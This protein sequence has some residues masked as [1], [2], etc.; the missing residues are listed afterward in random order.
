MKTLFVVEGTWSAKPYGL[1]Y[2]VVR[3]LH[4]DWNVIPVDYPQSF[5]DPLSFIRSVATGERNLRR[6]IKKAEGQYAI[7]GYSQGALV[8]GNVAA[9]LKDPRFINVYLIADPARS[10][11]DTLIGPPVLG[12]GIFGQRVVGPKAY[13]FAAAGDW[14]ADNCNPALS[15]MASYAWHM[16]WSDPHGWIKSWRITAR[17]RQHGGS[18]TRALLTVLKSLRNGVHIRYD[19]HVVAGT[20]TVTQ[21]IAHDLNAKITTV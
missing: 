9:T 4:S 12:E 13:Q 10:K 21:W 5:G 8:A 20:M 1:S 15:N 6:A 16:S 18:I 2:E 17:S 7:L 11:Q 14:I 19:K 3:L